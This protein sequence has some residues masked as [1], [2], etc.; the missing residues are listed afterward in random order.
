MSTFTGRVLLL[1]A[2]LSVVCL[3]PLPIA[4]AGAPM[5]VARTRQAHAEL[6][7]QRRLTDIVERGDRPPMHL[8]ETKAHYEK[9][10]ASGES[11]GGAAPMKYWGGPVM[12]GNPSVNVYIIYYGNWPSGSGQNVIENFIRSL[13]RDSHRQGEP[14]EPKVKYWWMINEPYFQKTDGGKRNVSRKVRLSG[15]VNDNYSAGK[16]FG[17][18]TVWQ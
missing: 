17:E 2:L 14:S 9:E 13:S 6:R 3:S 18:N 4:S 11:V 16:Q 12:V 15:T 7:R 5:R 8:F 10:R 1:L